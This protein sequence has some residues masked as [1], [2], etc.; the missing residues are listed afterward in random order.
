[1]GNGSVRLEF[2]DG[3]DDDLFVDINPTA[4]GIHNARIARKP[5][6]LDRQQQGLSLGG[7]GYAQR[8]F[9]R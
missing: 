5:T 9:L 6:S 4:S 1:M 3:G 8:A 7:F 2:G